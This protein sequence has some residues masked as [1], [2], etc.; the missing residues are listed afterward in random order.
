[1]D[2]AVRPALAFLIVGGLLLASGRISGHLALW[3]QIGVGLFAALVSAVWIS[4]SIPVAGRAAPVG[5]HV[6]WLKSAVPLGLVDLL[7]QLDGSYGVVLVGWLSTAVE[8]GVFRVAVACV[9]VA[10]MPVTIFHVL[11]APT[12]SR[13]FQAGQLAELQRLLTWT[14]RAMLAIMVPA[15]AIAWFAGK[16]LV[17]LVFGLPYQDAWLPLFILTLVQLTYAAFGMGP[18]LLAMCDSERD[19]IRIYAIAVGCALLAAIPMTMAWGGAGAAAGPVISAALIGLLS[20]RFARRQLGLE[21]TC[22]RWRH[23]LAG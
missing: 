1:M 13:L 4:R 18:I 20:R 14:S 10:S 5:S 15:T 9:V 3:V 12:I 19:L 7:R 2:I 23:A 11:L 17:G 6:P 21:I 22:L 8:L 16:F